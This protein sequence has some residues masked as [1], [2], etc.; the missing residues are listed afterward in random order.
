M[1]IISS[2]PVRGGYFCSRFYIFCSLIVP[3]IARILVGSDYRY[4]FPAS[5]LLGASL[6]MFCDSLG[7]II[8][9]PGEVPVG[10]IMSCIV[11]LL[12]LSFKEEG[13]AGLKVKAPD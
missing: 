13:Q 7:R 3:H 1:I 4:L 6:L 5:A 11:P 12:P 8:M 10:I 9:P 2:L